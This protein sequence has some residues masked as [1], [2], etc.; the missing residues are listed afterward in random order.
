MYS[1]LPYSYL[2]SIY[3]NDSIKLL[4]RSQDHAHIIGQCW[5][6]VTAILENFNHEQIM[7]LSEDSLS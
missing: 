1:Q 2:R 7:E 3:Q 5:K 4:A 6:P